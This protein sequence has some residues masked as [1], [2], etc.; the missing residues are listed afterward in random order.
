MSHAEHWRPVEARPVYEVSSDG[1]VRGPNGLLAFSNHAGGYDVVHLFY[2]DPMTVTVH[3]LVM[4][5]FRGPRP[6]GWVIAHKNG[7]RKDNRLAN[8]MY[9]TQRGNLMQA[10]W[11]GTAP[12]PLLA[13][14]NGKPRIAHEVRSRKA[15]GENHGNA[16][17]TEAQVMEVHR[18]YAIEP[19]AAKIDRDMGLRKNAAADIVSGRRWRHLHPDVNLRT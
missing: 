18:R 15:R 3:R 19:N 4:E 6:S 1:R 8:L 11:H 10:K 16:T 17:M 13:K 14:T 12:C 2:G 5:A 7:N 9:T